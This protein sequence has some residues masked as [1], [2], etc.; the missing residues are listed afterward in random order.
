MLKFLGL[1]P[2]QLDDAAQELWVVVHRRYAEFEGRSGIQ[3]WLFAIAVN[4]ERNFR[5]AERRRGSTVPLP[6]GLPARQGDPVLDQEAREAWELMLGFLETLDETRRTVFA[7]S[8]LAGLSAAETAEVTG[9]DQ[10]TVYNR[11][12]AL[13]RSFQLWI[14]QHRSEP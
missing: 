1:P 9:L 7:A 13:R 12:R 3:T 5:R 11:I 2:S 4:V 8:L 14:E 6:S 10:T